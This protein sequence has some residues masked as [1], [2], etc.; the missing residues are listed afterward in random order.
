MYYRVPKALALGCALGVAGCAQSGFGGGPG[1]LPPSGLS[2][3]QNP[4]GAGAPMGRNHRRTGSQGPQIYVFQGTPD[5]EVPEVGVVNVGSTLYGTTFEGGA[6]NLGAIYSVT[7]AGAE[8]VM[9]SFAGGSS[10]GEQS[11]APLT[12]VNGT[13]YGTT[14]YGGAD[15]VGTIFSITPAGSYNVIYSFQSNGKD[16]ECP[17]VAMVYDK[18]NKT[19]YGVAYRGGVDGEGAIFSLSLKGSKP[20]ESVVYSLTGSASSPSYASEPVLYK[21]A[22]YMTTVEGGANGL[23]A[24]IKVTLTGHESL[25]YSF[26]NEPDGSYPY[27]GLVA[28]GNALY[29]TTSSGGQG[30]CGGYGG[31]GTVYKVTPAGKEKVIHRF[32][33]VVSKIDGA[34]PTS[35][36]IAVGT[37][38]YGV[39]AGCTGESCDGGV[40]FAVTTSGSESIV[41]DF[42]NGGSLPPGSPGDPFGTVLDL[43]GKLYGTTAESTQTGYGTVYAVPL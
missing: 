3:L 6:N 35:P 38:L 37:T 25:V 5:A 18:S 39:S 17:Q 21:S 30:A 22:L 20:T 12:N 23:G 11:Y 4:A 9:H 24:V 7:T 29:G 14:Y 31:C 43:N 8:T 10:D 2:T 41:Y 19:L 13:L 34:T 1:A 16:A 28:V 36:L 15:G 26:K 32:T 40:I 42:K 33:D 27:A